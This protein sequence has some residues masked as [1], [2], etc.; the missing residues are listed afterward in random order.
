MAHLI[1][2][3][4]FWLLICFIVFIILMVKPFKKLMIGGLDDKIEEIKKNINISLESFKT[5]EH[6]LFEATKKTE[7]LNLRIKKL[8][9]NAQI[10]SETISNSI[11]EKTNNLINSKE[12]NSIERIKQIELSAIQE[13]KLG[14]SNK[15]NIMLI[16]Y[17]TDM[18]ADSKREILNKKISA[19]SSFQ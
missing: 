9:E 19:L 16:K 18:N 14:V 7:D 6:K 12:K 2:D 8:L 11:V 10:Q 17:F 3:P 4:K 13:I 15:L 1:E 5:A